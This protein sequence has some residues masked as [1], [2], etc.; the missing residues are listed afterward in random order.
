MAREN[1]PE[2][3]GT[4]TGSG[5]KPIVVGVDRS[6]TSIAAL[7][8][9]VALG[10]AL[11]LPVDV[12]SA[13]EWPSIFAGG[14]LPPSEWSPE[15]EARRTLDDALHTAFGSAR[16]ARVRPRTVHSLPAKA[17]VA[18]SATAHTVVLGR[19]GRG[20][21]SGLTMGSVTAAV[22]AHSVCPVVI[23]PAV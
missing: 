11:D 13:W 7:R 17:L 4:A 16:P 14:F 1:R 3:T 12:I 9:A 20:G 15:P 21:F 10:D 18:L 6:A 2:Q 22:A 23:V 19:R 8:Y 5:G